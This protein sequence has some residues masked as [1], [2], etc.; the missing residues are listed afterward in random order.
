M[1]GLFICNDSDGEECQGICFIEC[2][3]VIISLAKFPS[4]CF[5]LQ[6]ILNCASETSVEEMGSDK[7]VTHIKYIYLKTTRTTR[8]DI[9]LVF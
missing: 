1:L 9:I 2:A 5:L 8:F 7:F 3:D 4:S 6:L